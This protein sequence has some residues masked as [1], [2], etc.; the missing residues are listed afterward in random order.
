MWHDATPWERRLAEIDSAR[1]PLFRKTDPETSRLAVVQASGVTADHHRRILE[2]LK[3]GPGGAEVI[4]ARAGLEKH[5]VQKRLC[6]MGR[7]GL[8]ETTGRKLVSETGSLEREW[9][10]KDGR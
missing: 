5:R 1:H 9:R 10:A 8:I 7:A 4:G 3:L 6:E 2:A